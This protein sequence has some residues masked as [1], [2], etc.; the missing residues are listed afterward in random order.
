MDITARILQEAADK[1]PKREFSFEDLN[2]SEVDAVINANLSRQI[3]VGYQVNGSDKHDENTRE[4]D[5]R[6][7]MYILGRVTKFVFNYVAEYK[8]ASILIQ[9]D[10]EGG[11]TAEKRARVYKSII[12]RYASSIGYTSKLCKG[13]RG[14]YISMEV[15]H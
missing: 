8:P 15:V 1:L 10:N 12:D 3:I 14:F 5:A 4:P 2:G 9:S 6:N 13:Q 11:N 7:L